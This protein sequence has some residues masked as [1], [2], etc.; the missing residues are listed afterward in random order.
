MRSAR[1][2]GGVSESVAG[3]LIIAI[4]QPHHRAFGTYHWCPGTSVADDSRR[5]DGAKSLLGVQIR[6]PGSER[7]RSPWCM[8]VLRQFSRSSCTPASSSPCLETDLR[9]HV[10]KATDSVAQIFN[11]LGRRFVIG[12]TL[13]CCCH[14]EIAHAR[15]NAILRY[16]RLKT[17]A[18]LPNALR[19]STVA[20]NWL[21]SRF[22]L[23]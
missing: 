6:I 23:D 14:C 1:G 4:W 17:C 12:S 8:G 10:D 13:H 11:L 7:V 21:L 18:T 5:L 20:E 22:S 19:A 3:C 9:P 2:S 15:K 16:G